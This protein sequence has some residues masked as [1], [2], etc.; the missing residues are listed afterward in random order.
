M[1]GGPPPEP[2]PV[3]A[4]DTV[5]LLLGNWAAPG[6]F[7]LLTGGAIWRVFMASKSMVTRQEFD[8]RIGTL[9]EWRE[10][11]E[12]E[13]ARTETLLDMLVKQGDEAK[14]DRNRQQE[15]MNQMLDKLVDISHRLRH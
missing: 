12:P 4:F 9:E 10:R 2:P 1:L 8:E 13:L 14:A 5:R 6:T 15:R 7:L 3:G 11:T